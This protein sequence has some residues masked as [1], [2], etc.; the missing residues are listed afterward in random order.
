MAKEAAEFDVIV[1]GGG[2]AG[3]TAAMYLA[4]ARRRVLVVEPGQWGGNIALTETVENYPGLPHITGPALGQAMKEQALSHGAELLEAAALSLKSEGDWKILETTRGVFR[5]R[6]L[7]AATGTRPRQVGF[8][9]ERAFRGRG[10]SVCATCDGA[11]FR[12][13]EVFLVGGG[14]AAAEEGVYLTQFARHVTILLR[15]PDFSC[16]KSLADRAKSHEKITVLPNTV[17]EAVTGDAFVTGVRYRNMATGAVTDYRA[18]P[19][20]RV[21]VFVFA[22]YEPATDWLGDQVQRDENGYLTTNAA[23]ETNIPNLCAAG[24]LRAK[25]LRQLVTATNDGAQSATTLDKS[26]GKRRASGE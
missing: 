13:Q 21:G 6:G 17:M 1:V 20:Q 15:K 9:G 26:L 23:L 4:R 12:D 24:D 7:I 14:Y 5:C 22:G 10:V 2:P 18:E 11:F 19:G 3:L 8:A 16:A 25:P